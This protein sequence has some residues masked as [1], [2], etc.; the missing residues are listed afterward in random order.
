MPRL[1]EPV[2]DA[3]VEL[4]GIGQVAR[5]R[6]QKRPGQRAAHVVH[7]DVQPPKLGHRGRGQPGH[8]VQIGQVR[9]HHQRPPPGRCHLLG[10]LGQLVF[11]P[12]RDQHVGPGF[13]QRHRDGRADPPARAGHHGHLAGNAARPR[14]PEPRC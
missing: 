2:R 3:H 12:C 11:G 13:G 4:E 6:G 5:L 1:G 10:H 7:H 9:G 8:G 14:S